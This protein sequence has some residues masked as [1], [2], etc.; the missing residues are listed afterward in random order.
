MQSDKYEV[1]KDIWKSKADSNGTQKEVALEIYHHKEHTANLDRMMNGMKDALSYFSE[2][3]G[4]YQHRQLRIIEFPRYQSFAQSFANT[5]PYSEE[6]GFM[7]NM[8][9]D[10]IDMNY[11]VTAHETAHQWWGHQVTEAPVQGSSMLS[12]TLSQYSALMVMKHKYPKEMIQKFLKYELESYLRGRSGER[13]KELPLDLVER[14]QYIH[15]RKGS[16]I[17]FALQDYIGEDK[18]NTAMRNFLEEFKYQKPPYPTSLDF[19]KYLELQIPDS[20]HYLIDDWFKEITL[21]DNRL[22]EASYK[23]LENGKYEV[24]MNIESYKIKADTIGNET[25]VPINDWID[26]GVFFDKEEE[27]LLFEKRVKIDRPEMSFSF[28]VD[29]L[30]VKAAIDPRHLLIDRVYDDNSKTLVLE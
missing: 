18:V 8:K 24:S 3:F 15:Y 30:P 17:M 21:Y 6:I 23:E 19:M 26:I 5:V 1:M 14:Q 10:D 27:H 22:N 12:E 9:K 7:L 20:L 25:R 4:E 16:L 28:V 2:N 11:Y 29:S 13:K